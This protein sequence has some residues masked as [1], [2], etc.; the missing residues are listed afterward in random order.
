MTGRSRSALIR[1]GIRTAGSLMTDQDRLWS[2]YSND[3]VDIGEKLAGVIRTLSVASPLNRKL[4]ALSIGSSNEPQFRILETAFRGGLYL[5]DIDQNA[6]DLVNER[7]RRQHTAHVAT[8]QGDYKEAFFDAGHTRAF[9][10]GPLKGKKV[11]LITLHHSLYYCQEAQ[12]SALFE[13]IY[14]HLL[15]RRGAIHAVMM[16]PVSRNEKT[17]TWLYNH[18]AG[19]YFGICNNQ[20]LPD[21]KKEL[22]ENALFSDAQILVSPST[23]EFYVDDFLKFMEVVWMILLYPDVHRY[24]DDQIEEIVTYVHDHFWIERSPLQ[25]VQHHMVIYRGI[26]FKGLI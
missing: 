25:Q 11:D 3:K 14:R 13:N 9:F 16:T 7:I 19:K 20:S 23:V 8:I 6:L 1:E 15:A 26:D 12:W 22:E 18:F 5:F 24:S 4:R 21:L 17:T 10:S 2:Q